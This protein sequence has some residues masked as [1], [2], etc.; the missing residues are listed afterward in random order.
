MQVAKL[1]KEDWRMV[2]QLGLKRLHILCNRVLFKLNDRVLTNI[3]YWF[4]GLKS[5]L[6]ALYSLN[7]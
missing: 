7:P 6:I 4:I 3:Y 2:L 5:Y 1:I